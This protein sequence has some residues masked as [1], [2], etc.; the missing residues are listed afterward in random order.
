MLGAKKQLSTKQQKFNLKS[1]DAGKEELTRKIN[2]YF[3]K[4]KL[5]KINKFYNQLKITG[6]KKREETV[7][8]RE[9]I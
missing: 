3:R 8:K 5:L 7:T 1:W 9:A 2:H 4:E 6:K